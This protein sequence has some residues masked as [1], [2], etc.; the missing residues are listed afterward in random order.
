MFFD[1]VDEDI[2]KKFITLTFRK[3]GKKE[4]IGLM[5]PK[6]LYDKCKEIYN[7]YQFGEAKI[8]KNKKSKKEFMMVIGNLIFFFEYL[9]EKEYFNFNFLVEYVLNLPD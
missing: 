1:E 2:K 6:K 3:N 7:S 5:S 8:E 4:T 9:W